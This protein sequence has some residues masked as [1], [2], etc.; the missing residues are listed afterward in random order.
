MDERESDIEHV[1]AQSPL[2]ERS[3]RSVRRH[4]HFELRELRPGIRSA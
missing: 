1:P 3:I 2:H 4:R